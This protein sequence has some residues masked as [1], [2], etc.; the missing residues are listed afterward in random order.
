ML[1]RCICWMY[2]IIMLFHITPTQMIFFPQVI[3]NKEIKE[4]WSSFRLMKMEKHGMFFKLISLAKN[5]I[6]QLVSTSLCFYQRY[7]KSESPPYHKCIKRK[8][9]K[10]K[11]V[12]FIMLDHNLCLVKKIFVTSWT[13]WLSTMIQVGCQLAYIKE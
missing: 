10:K 13:C 1:E 7:T 11:K 9:K 12:S 6:T 3:S 8:E 5:L 4:G 2:K